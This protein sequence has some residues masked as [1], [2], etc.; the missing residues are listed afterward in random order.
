M[1]SGCY[2]PPLTL[3]QF[4]P[5]PLCIPS[6]SCGLGLTADSCL[7]PEESTVVKILNGESPGHKI[8]IPI[9]S[10]PFPDELLR[11]A[12]IC[13]I[14]RDADRKISSLSSDHGIYPIIPR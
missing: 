10:W 14:N 7:G 2:Y 8:R 6:V 3:Y 12:S 9:H 11:K 4:P 5:K 1:L 13:Q